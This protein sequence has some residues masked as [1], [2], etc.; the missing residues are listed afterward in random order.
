MASIGEIAAVFTSICFTGTAVL[1]TLSG[2]LV[3]SVV[4]NRTRVVFALVYLAVWNLFLFGQPLP[5]S[6]EPER[7]LWF[8]L[9][10]VIGLA[11]GDAFLFQAYVWIGPRL[12][13]LLMSLSP[14]FGALQAWAFFGETLVPGQLLGMGLTLAGIGWVVLERGNGTAPRPR[15]P[16]RGVVFGILAAIGQA[17]GLV[18]SKQGLAGGFSPVS[19][20]M[21]RMLAAVATLWLITA[22]QG[23]AGSTLRTLRQ[24]PAALRLLLLG[25]LVG[26]VVGVSAS[27][28]AVQHAEIGVASTL[29]ALP[30][31]FLL[32]VGYFVFKERFGW[33]AVAGTLLAISGVALLFLF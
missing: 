2:R 4:T 19:G 29:M 13:M 14:I 7:W 11:L 20:N 26:P 27:L 8:S 5:L 18:L 12:G 22:L 10:G 3:G 33:Q 30:P 16:L 1:F 32:P 15:A 9:S 21:I 24:N 31:V 25:S 23:Q 6:A 28:L 17:T